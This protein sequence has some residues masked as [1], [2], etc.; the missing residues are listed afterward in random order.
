MSV[1]WSVGPNT[2]D[3]HENDGVSI[4]PDFTPVTTTTMI[5]TLPPMTR[6]TPPITMLPTLPF[7]T[8]CS[9]LRAREEMERGKE[10]RVC[11]CMCM[12]VCVYVCE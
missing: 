1:H 7:M 9:N 3:I 2:K 6:T 10:R 12:C 8:K 5:L 4:F 11:A